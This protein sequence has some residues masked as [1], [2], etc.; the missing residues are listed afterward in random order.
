MVLYFLSFL[1]GLVFYTLLGKIL[2]RK[3]DQNFFETILAGA[4]F[5]SFLA[6]LVNFFFA[7]TPK[8]N[9]LIFL[10]IFFLFIKQNNRINFKEIK[11]ILFF[12]FVAFGITIY[13]TVNRPDAYLY[14]LP[15]T[16]ILN[17]NKI[18]FGLSNLHFRYAHIS[19]IQYLSAFNYSLITNENAI[20]APLALVWTICVSYF[21]Y[22]IYKLISK[23]E[24]FSLGKVFSILILIYITFKINRYSE[25]G[26]DAISHLAFFVVVSK[27]LYYKQKSNFDLYLINLLCAFCIVNKIFL[28]FSIIIPL[29]IIFKER[30]NIFKFF[31]TLPF[32]IILF[33]L[34][35][36]IIVSGCVIFPIKITCS[37]NFSW[38]NMQQIERESLSGE[39]WAKAWPQR[40]NKKISMKNFNENFNWFE[41]WNKVH[42][43]KI[44]K[45]LIPYSLI[46]L[47]LFFYIRGNKLINSEKDKIN[48]ILLMSFL[49][50]II[51]FIKFPLYRYG[52]SYL[53]ILLSGIFIFFLKKINLDRFYSSIKFIL[54]LSVIILSAKQFQRYFEYQKLREP[55]PLINFKKDKGISKKYKKI[56]IGEKFEYYWSDIMCMYYLAPCTSQNPSEISHK[57][58]FGYDLLY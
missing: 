47:C 36:N 33:W 56:I 20:L 3:S 7:L 9:F 13:D 17:E 44:M 57:K 5:A 45:I 4:I 50:S 35:K 40:S 48:L 27:F 12:A 32:L 28:G 42:S 26:N 2:I 1:Q 8:I 11:L 49:G 55:I 15:Y 58:V 38:T 43:K 10:L 25:F 22:D 30:L 34:L 41:A 31:K 51:F 6:L 21:I 19:L 39:A 54:I 29:F 52:Y 24:S 37:E 23:K 16:H 14:H 53:I 46:I 18:I